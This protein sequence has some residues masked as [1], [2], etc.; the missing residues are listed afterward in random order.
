MTAKSREAISA[1]RGELLATD[2]ILHAALCMLEDCDKYGQ[3]DD[4]DGV[5]MA[6]VGTILIDTRSRIDRLHEQLSGIETSLATG[7]GIE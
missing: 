4:L 7:E 6:D 5:M 1:I 3:A 2:A